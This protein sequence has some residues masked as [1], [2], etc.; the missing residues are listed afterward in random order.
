MPRRLVAFL[1][2]FAALSLTS[3]EKAPLADGSAPTVQPVNIATPT[4]VEMVLLPGGE[5]TM[6]SARGEADEGPPHAVRVSPLAMD[7]F[8]V[9]QDQYAAME[10]PDPSHFK[11]EKRPVEQVRWS[12]AAL[13]CNERSRREG[14]TPCYDEAT[15][16]CDFQASG[17]RLPTEAE[18]EYA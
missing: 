4:G 10:L 5:F 2:L 14:L 17:Y 18:W 7:K 15:F 11:G 13:F 6:G 1:V 16:D 3:C 9:T 12:D 8:E